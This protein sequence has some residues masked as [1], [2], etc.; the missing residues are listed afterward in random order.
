MVEPQAGVDRQTVRHRD[1]VARKGRGRDKGTAYHRRIARD[2]LKR[3]SVVVD[4][5]HSGR[6][7]TGPVGLALLDLPA[8]LPLVIGA[9]QR[10]TVVVERRFRGRPNQRQSAERLWSAAGDTRHAIGPARR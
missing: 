4:E 7:D 5:P 6:N 3:P 1:R 2:G 8:D 9:E 10:W